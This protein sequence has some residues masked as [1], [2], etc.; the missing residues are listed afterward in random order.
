MRT[1][2]IFLF[3][4]FILPFSS[5]A[6]NFS[7]YAP[8]LE[9]TTSMPSLYTCDGKNIS[10][11]LNW[12][13]APSKT[14]TFTLIL[15]DP[16]APSGIFYHWILYNVPANVS[17]LPENAVTLPKGTEPGINSLGKKTY[18]GPCPPKKTTHHYIFTL[19]ALDTE[20]QSAT[21]LSADT[22]LTQLT[23]HVLAKTELK[24]TYGH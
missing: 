7:L 8:A 2:L 11:A 9:K 24:T 15:S 1:K 21:T 19:Y 6:A 22:L 20:I 3:L 16:D 13:N 5:Y 18:N 10:P 23:G 4:L 17:S 14:K 12:A